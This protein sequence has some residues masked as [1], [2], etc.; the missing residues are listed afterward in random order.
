MP[1]HE[2]LKLDVAVHRDLHPSLPHYGIGGAFIPAA[3]KW[4]PPSSAVSARR[5]LA[6]HSGGRTGHGCAAASG[7]GGGGRPVG[8][9]RRGEPAG[10]KRIYQ[11]PARLPRRASQGLSDAPLAS[12]NGGG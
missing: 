10:R 4:P 12:P 5:S 8:R 7:R 9:R 11:E 3:T 6:A 1:E 2:P